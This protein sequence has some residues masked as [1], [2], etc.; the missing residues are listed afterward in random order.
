MDLSKIIVGNG[1]G[2]VKTHEDVDRM[3]GSPANRIVA[4]SY[5]M[6]PRSGNIGTT[7]YHDEENNAYYNALGLPNQGSTSLYYSLPEMA[8]LAH[9]WGKELVV[10]VA[11]F[12]PSEYADMAL[13]AYRCGADLVRL[14]LGCPNVHGVAGQKPIPSYYPDLIEDIL[15]EVK[16]LLPTGKMVSV[17]ISPIVDDKLLAEVVTAI[18]Y[19]QVVSEI[20]ACNTVPNQGLLLP[21]GKEALSFR[22]SEGGELLHTGGLS[23]APLKSR[24]LQMMQLLTTW[25]PQIQRIGCGGIFTGDDALE[26]LEAGAHGFEVATAYLLH[27]P[28][29][30]G[31]IY[32]R[33]LEI[34]PQSTPA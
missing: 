17:K 33:L 21:N 26:Y 19:S 32:A 4:G 16:S 29:I 1:G 12:D 7:A 14:N 18:E 30:F 20:V 13:N 25:V 3:T 23:G 24:S 22:S 31:D 34:A 2:M 15:Q 9:T 8:R 11:G 28:R 27:G 6:D 10:D 5:T